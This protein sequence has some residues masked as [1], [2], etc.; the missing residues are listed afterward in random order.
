[1]RVRDVTDDRGDLIKELA[2]AVSLQ[3][4]VSNRSWLTL[5]LVSVV[6]LLPREQATEVSLPLG[7]GAVSAPWFHF[8]MFFLLVILGIGFAAAHAQQ[9]RAERLAYDALKH[10]VDEPLSALRIRPRDLFEVLRIPSVNYIAPIAQQFR[11][12]HKFDSSAPRPPSWRQPASK[13]YYV[14][15]KVVSWFVYFGLPLLALWLSFARIPW[16][17]PIHWLLF[18]AGAISTVPVVHM[19]LVELASL[20]RG[21]AA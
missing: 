4:D 17:G 13:M 2:S 16:L 11:D 6:A 12:P 1:M 14:S 15:L 21:R 5:I 10:L 19:L 8:V 7:L 3:T 18:V 9:V 20:V